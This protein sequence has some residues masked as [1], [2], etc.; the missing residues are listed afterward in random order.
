MRRRRSSNSRI[1]RQKPARLPYSNVPF[2][3]AP[4]AWNGLQSNNV[5][6]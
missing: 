3:V 4:T 6:H 5:W 1:T 2:D